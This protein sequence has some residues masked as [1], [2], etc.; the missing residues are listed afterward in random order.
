MS[1]DEMYLEQPGGEARGH[2]RA[3]ARWLGEVPAEELRDKRRE[4]DLLVH[5]VGITFAVYGDEDGSERLIA[6]ERREC[7]A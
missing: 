1:Y 3:F 4:A 6:F 5:R 2:Y 7:E